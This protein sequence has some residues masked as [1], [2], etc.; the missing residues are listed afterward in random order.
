M[1]SV[2]RGIDWWDKWF[3]GMAE[4]VSTASKDPSTKIGAV[5][6]DKDRRIVSTGYNGFAKGIED[7]E[8]LLLDRDKKYKIIVHGEMNAIIFAQRS[9]KG[10]T[11]YTTPFLPCSSCAGVIIQSGITR[12]VSWFTNNIRWK[13]SID[14]SK[15]MFRESGVKFYDYYK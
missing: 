5:I 4:Y 14:L 2:T 9:L 11:L 8:E 13:E 7:S 15:S 10:C 1:S 3:L 12:V 6:V